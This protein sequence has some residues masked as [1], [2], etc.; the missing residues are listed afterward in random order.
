VPHVRGSDDVVDPLV[1]FNLK[2]K[3]GDKI[4][5]NVPAS[6][7]AGGDSDI[8]YEVQ[9]FAEYLFTESVSGRLGYRY[10][11][12]DIDGDNID[13]EGS[14]NGFVLGVGFIF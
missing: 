3:L 11:Y 9:P 7:G 4:F 10:L 1:G 5:V 6:I 13:F 12:Y 14:F 8:V 2:M